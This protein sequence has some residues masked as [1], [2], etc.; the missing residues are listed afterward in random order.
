MP[1]LVHTPRFYLFF[2]SESL[3]LLS[4]SSADFGLFRR[5]SEAVRDCLLYL[6][7]NFKFET[8]TDRVPMPVHTPRI[9]FFYYSVCVF[10]FF[11][12]LRRSKPPSTT[13]RSRACRFIAFNFRFEIPTD[14][15]FTLVHTPRI[16]FLFILYFCLFV[17]FSYA[18]FGLLRRD[19]EAV[20]D[21]VLY[22]LFNSKFEIPTDS[23][24]TPVPT[25]ISFF[26][27][28]CFFLL[29]LSSADLGLL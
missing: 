26:H 1:T 15:V 13:S 19:S 10:F 12:Q 21:Y 17:S 14:S 2:Y 22:L 24:P 23:V 18:D 20:Y 5:D 6:I 7:L 28:E 16:S 27:S 9:S 8:P 3:F 4:F 11:F 25:N 29:S